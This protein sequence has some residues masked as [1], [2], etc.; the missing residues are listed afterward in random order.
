MA[1]IATVPPIRFINL[2]SSAGTGPYR[3]SQDDVMILRAFM[4]YLQNFRQDLPFTTTRLQVLK[5]AF[6]ADLHQMI[7]DYKA[8]KTKTVSAGLPPQE[9][10]NDRVIPQD[11]RFALQSAGSSAVT[12]TI[13]CLNS[14]VKPLA[15]Y[16]DSTVDVMC[17]LFPI[18]GKLII[19]SLTGSALWD[20]VR[21]P[22]LS[23]RYWR[24]LA[25]NK[26]PWDQWLPKQ[27]ED[28]MNER[29]GAFVRAANQDR[30]K[31]SPTYDEDNELFSLL[32]PYQKEMKVFWEHHT[33][34]EISTTPSPSAHAKPVTVK[35]TL[36]SYGGQPPLGSVRLWIA[37]KEQLRVY[38][39]QFILTPQ[40]SIAL[41]IAN[42]VAT[43]AVPPDSLFMG[44][45]PY[46]IYA[47][48]WPKAGFLGSKAEIRHEVK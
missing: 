31:L 8:F 34:M 6:D 46:V 42:G 21:D 11:L 5:G 25:R 38:G 26:I 30:N 19:P 39:R 33:R 12:T 10:G 3:N 32:A 37:S 22:D 17:S 23:S 44:A 36:A 48:Y 13:M 35:I 29:Q 9:Q 16:G 43:Y 18:K 45:S 4:I 2:T 7:V 40:R 1:Y 24:D 47:E 28:A 41:T 15:S 27:Q 14:D 20:Q